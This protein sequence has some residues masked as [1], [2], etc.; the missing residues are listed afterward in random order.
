MKWWI[1][2]LK[3]KELYQWYQEQPQPKCERAKFCARVTKYWYDKQEALPIE[4][5][6]TKW[7]MKRYKSE[8]GEDGRVCNKCKKYKQRNEFAKNK[9]WVKG[10]TCVC[11]ECRNSYHREFREK[12]NHEWDRRYKLEKRHLERWDQ[13][14]FNSEIRE[15]KEYRNKKWYTVK[16]IM[17][18]AERVISTSDNHNRPNN[19]CIRFVKLRNPIVMMRTKE[20]PQFEVKTDGELF[21]LTPPPEKKFSL[22]LDDLLECEFE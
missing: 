11:K 9:E 4:N 18:W 21:E 13:I 20:K 7:A 19:S 6:F 14:Y 15:V 2:H 3:H 12:T 1:K 16:S 10:H 5:Q 22:D 8:I 17:T